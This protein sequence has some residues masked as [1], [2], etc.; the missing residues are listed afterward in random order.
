MTGRRLC[1]CCGLDHH[2]R[3]VLCSVCWQ[4]VPAKLR[5]AIYSAQRALGYNPA[6][7]ARQAE[8][9]QAIADACGAIS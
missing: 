8:L 3:D 7:A 9:E 4:L 6:S 1:R 2:G 5:A